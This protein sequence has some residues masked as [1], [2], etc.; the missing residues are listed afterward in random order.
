MAFPPNVED[1]KTFVSSL[2]RYA[3]EDSFISLRAFDQ[4]ER[5]RPPILIEGVR[6]GEGSEQ[7]VAKAARASVRAANGSRPGVFAPPVATFMSADSAAEANVANGVAISVEIDEGDPVEARKRLEHILGPATLAMHSGSEWMDPETGEIY[8]KTHLHWRLSEPTRQADEH[9]MLK[10]ARWAAAVL[11]GADRT[12]APPCHPLRWPGWNLKGAPRPAK[13]FAGN[14]ASEVHLSDVLEK[15]EEA[16]EAAGLKIDTQPRNSGVD[17][18]A[19]TD[20]IREALENIPNNDVDWLMW[21]HLGMATWRATGGSPDGMMAWADWSAKSGKHH[22]DDC[23]ARWQHYATSPPSK[24]GAGT[25]FYTAAQNGW[26]A[27]WQREDVGMDE[28][29]SPPDSAYDVVRG[30]EAPV[31]AKP[32]DKKVANNNEAELPLLWFGDIHPVLEAKDFVQGTLVENSSVVIYGKSNAGKT[33]WVTDLALHVAAGKE[34]CGKRVEQG[35]VIYCVLEG[36]VGF[37]NRVSAWKD[38]NGYEDGI[39]PFAAIPAQINLLD[40]N[41]DADRLI[42]AIKTAQARME[43]PVKMV[44]IDTLARALAGGNENAPEDMG[45]LVMN[46][47]RVRAET[48]ACVIFVHHSGKDEA[49]G[50]RGHSS[51]QAAID[52]EI[53]VVTDAQGN[54][55]ATVVKQRDLSKGQIYGFTLDVVTIGHNRH[56]EE[57]TTC[58]VKPSDV[59]VEALQAKTSIPAGAQG[60]LTALTDA[61]VEVGRGGFP[62]VPSGFLSISEQSWRNRFY[63]SNLPGED[64]KAKGQAFRRASKCLIEK[65]IAAMGNGRVWLTHMPKSTDTAGDRYEEGI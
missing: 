44:V 28:Q 15:L 45:A 50:A 38:K 60:A 13:I 39:I 41:A 57:V 36:G 51:L 27:S 30:A 12:A 32:A 49:K 61:V 1:I 11:V 56:G 35:G 17:P 54:K 43:M 16:V 31:A 40:P 37:H 42:R 8:P 7:I 55:T 5:G 65:K 59:P 62:G 10:R 63:S 29:P 22:E 14:A 2:F 18:Q 20:R 53:E 4:T 58:T 33:F 25:I 48:G 23:L 47:D 64:A 26:E 3:D 9:A 52:T 24:V 21:N 19:R 46:T 34:W 6:V